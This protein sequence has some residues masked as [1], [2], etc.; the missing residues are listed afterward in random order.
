MTFSAIFIFADNCEAFLL[1]IKP[2]SL[3]MNMKVG[4]GTT[5]GIFTSSG[6]VKLYVNVCMYK[7]MNECMYV[8]QP[9]L[10][11]E[12]PLLLLGGG[13]L[14]QGQQPHVVARVRVAVRVAL[15]QAGRQP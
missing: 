10:F 9:A 5:K 13:G 2:A 8:G 3:M 14:G 11:L 12:Q 6:Q 1:I 7:C 4:Y 15:R